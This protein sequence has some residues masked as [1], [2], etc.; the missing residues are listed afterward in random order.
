MEWKD[1]MQGAADR[2]RVGAPLREEDV[3]PLLQLAAEDAISLGGDRYI[4]NHADYLVAIQT[5]EGEKCRVCLAGAAM[6]AT[7]A[8]DPYEAGR[9]VPPGAWRALCAIDAARYGA[10]DA[11]F[12]SLGFAR[13]EWLSER[14][15]S[16]C[17]DGMRGLAQFRTLAGLKRCAREVL[18]VVAHC[19]DAEEAY[20]CRA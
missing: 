20:A 12:E 17:R 19:V 2:F 13:P 11:I 16:E 4:G 10:M 18:G 1:R 6:A 9:D 14:L 15:L 3:L 8:C 7:L 5:S